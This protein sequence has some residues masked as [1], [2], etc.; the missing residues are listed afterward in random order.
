[1]SMPETKPSK[2]QQIAAAVT[3][4]EE[5]RTGH[6]PT[7]ATVLLGGDALVVTLHG[8]LSPAERAL[9]QTPAGAAEVQEF[10]RVLFAG[11][12]ALLLEEIRC[13]TG[14]EVREAAAE[15]PTAAGALVHAFTSGTLVQVF[16]LARSLPLESWSSSEPMDPA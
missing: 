14:A 10:H 3:A 6:R 9:A 2:A 15:V 11:S 16:L 12:S 1:M 7:S 4:F 5:H 8:T 13:I